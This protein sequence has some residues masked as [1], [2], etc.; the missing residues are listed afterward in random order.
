MRY[1]QLPKNT[2]LS[3][4]VFLLTKEGYKFII[5]SVS[6]NLFNEKGRIWTGLREFN[7]WPF[8]SIDSWLGCMKE[9]NGFAKDEGL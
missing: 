3:F 7:I 4:N 8:Y 9:Y 5:G 1:C 2:W 6:V